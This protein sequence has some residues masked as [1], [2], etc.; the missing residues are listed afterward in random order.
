MTTME[1]VMPNDS[2]CI[3]VNGSKLVPPD[4]LV[5]KNYLDPSVYKFANQKRHLPVTEVTIHE[6]VT[7]SWQSTVN[8][9]KPASASNPGGRGLGVHFIVDADGTIYQHGDLALDM[10]WH[11]S[12]HNDVA[13]GIETVNP[14]DPKYAPHN[15]PWKDIIENAPWAVGGRY[16]VPTPEQSE[17]VCQ[18]L[19]W[20]CSP[21][22]NLTIP[23]VFVGLHHNTMA[24]GPFDA[25]KSWS[26]GVYAHHY[27]G[28][29]DGS[30][31]VLYSWLRLEA[32]MDP[33]TARSTAIQLATGARPS[34]VDVTPYSA[35]PVTPPGNS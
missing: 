23:L 8:V 27:F 32:G 35:G 29:G 20:L 34:G 5:V 9:L 30:W 19:L 11:A 3:I 2:N 15:S 16:L 1:G 4:G 21:Q 18:L 25:A 31:L 26:P 12:Q 7:S 24:M 14:F 33:A 6:T 17:A 22:S 13:V 10:L 28:H